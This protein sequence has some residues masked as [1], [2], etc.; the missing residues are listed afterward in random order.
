MHSMRCKWPF[1]SRGCLVCYRVTASPATRCAK[2]SW[3]NDTPSWRNAYLRFCWGHT[4]FCFMSCVGQS[5]MPD[6][7]G[8]VLLDLLPDLDLENHEYHIFWCS[9]HTVHT[10][11]DHA[12][13]YCSV[14]WLINA[15]PHLA[16]PPRDLMSLKCLSPL[17]QWPMWWNLSSWSTFRLSS[18]CIAQEHLWWPLDCPCF[19]DTLQDTIT[20]SSCSS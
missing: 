3:W 20:W 7:S 18:S 16:A 9:L 12:A 5:N 13:S 6:S 15:L 11:S 2:V 10:G 4:N 19:A 14:G 1:H 17:P 8:D